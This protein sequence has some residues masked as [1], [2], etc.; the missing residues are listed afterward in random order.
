MTRACVHSPPR[1]RCAPRRAAA[2]A[3][4]TPAATPVSPAA[5]AAVADPAPAEPSPVTAQLEADTNLKTASGATFSV[6]KGWWITERSEVV[7][8]EDPDRE[9]KV[10]LVEVKGGDAQAALD[11]GWEKAKPAG[12]EKKVRDTVKPPARGPW[13]AIEQNVYD[14]GSDAHRVLVGA[15][16]KKGD[17]W[18]VAFLDGKDA[19]VDR[20]GAQIGTTLNGFKPAGAEEEKLGGRKVHAL[21]AERA[22][23]FEAF[24]VEAMKATDVPGAAVAVV[25]D[26]KVVYEKAFGVRELGN[27]AA[28]TPDT[29]FMIGSTT[30][31]LTT[32]LMARLVD[33]KKF[34]WD[35]PVVQVMPSFALGDPE[36]TKKI[37]MRHT[38]CA[39]TGLPRQDMEFIFEFAKATPEQRLAQLATMKPTTGFGET[40]QYSNP[41]VS[42]GGYAAAYSVDPQRPIGPAY[43]ALMTERVFAP[44]GMT[45]TTFDLASKPNVPHASPHGS[46]LD[47]KVVPV[48][49]TIEGA[50]LSVR[51]AGGAWSNVRDLSRYILVEL[52]RGKLD[53]KEVVSE[54]NLLER[55]K[56]MVRVSDMSSYGL[57]LFVDDYRGLKIVHHGGNTLGFTSDL[58]VFPEHGTGAVVLTN[59]GGANTFRAT[60]RRRL[61]EVLFDAAPEAKGNLE[62]AVKRRD[63]VVAKERA[64]L[65]PAD[66]AW[67]RGV[68]GTYENPS[69]GTVVVTVKGKKATV[70]AGEWKAEAAEHKDDDGALR[71]ITVGAPIPGIPFLPAEQDGK[72]ALRLELPQQ[73]YVF[74]RK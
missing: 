23:A 6:P 70:D 29:L 13:D 61:I 39:C 11:A 18:H 53:G 24:V 8:L 10:T 46:G 31:S 49:L 52:E 7:V 41:L 60:V 9:L 64:K 34:D 65:V 55:R 30:K 5:P 67:L 43:D 44:L 40:F 1:S 33:D 51:P 19:A 68:A 2:V 15:A 63:E 25:Q 27:K 42:A 14:T 58:F 47:L 72:K 26:G 38:V 71:L 32:L 17:R 69:L 66:A 54:K 48:P 73:T 16:R 37:A 45:S 22:A 59:G 50:V 36:A 28:V 4:P 74:V 12:V 20:R 21:D 56:P 62:F 3:T 57:G 35:T